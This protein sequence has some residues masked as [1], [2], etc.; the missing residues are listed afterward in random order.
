MEFKL[1]W[2][3]E[4]WIHSAWKEMT[5]PCLEAWFLNLVLNTQTTSDHIHETPKSNSAYV[6]FKNVS[7]EAQFAALKTFVT[8]ELFDVKSQIEFS[9]KAGESNPYLDSLQDQIHY[10]KGKKET[11]NIFKTFWIIKKY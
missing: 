10:L 4:N 8:A 11:N 9:I 1:S 6:D 3:M 5:N 7:S 2:K